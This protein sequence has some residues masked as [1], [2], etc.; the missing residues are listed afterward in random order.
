MAGGWGPVV[1][2]GLAAAGAAAVGTV[3]AAVGTVW[4]AVGTVWGGVAGEMALVDWAAAAGATAVAAAGLETESG[5]SSGLTAC[6]RSLAAQS[7]CH[8]SSSTL[9]P[10][11]HRSMPHSPAVRC[12]RSSML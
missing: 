3:W 4:A 10:P 1:A 7:R 2:L 9:S 5:R 6:L 12:M 8:A 11:S